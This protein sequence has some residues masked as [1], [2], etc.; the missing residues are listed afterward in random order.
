MGAGGATSASA[1]TAGAPLRME[2]FMSQDYGLLQD[3]LMPSS[4]AHSDGTATN[5]HN[6]HNR[7]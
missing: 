4:F 6:S 7:R 3:M 5:S 1:A 2:H